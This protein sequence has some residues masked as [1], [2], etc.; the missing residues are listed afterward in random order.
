MKVTAKQQKNHR[1]RILRQARIS[2]NNG[3]HVV[4]VPPR[5]KGPVVKNWPVLRLRKDQLEEYFASDDNIGWMTGETSGD[6]VDVD[7]DCKAAIV[8]GKVFLPK[9][10]RIHG[11]EGRRT[12]HYWYGAT[13]IPRP[14]KFVDVDGKCLVEL[15]SDGQQTLI[16]PSIHPNGEQLRWEGTGEPTRIGG[17]DLCKAVRKIAAGALLARH[18]PKLGRRHDAANA[19]A[20]MLL[21]GGWKKN[22]T[23]GF[24]EAVAEAAGDDESRQRVKDVMSTATRIAS[25]AAATG[26]PSLAVIMG[27]DVVSRIRQILQIAA[28]S[29]STLVSGTEDWPDPAL[30]GDELLPVKKFRL[31]LLPSSFRPLVEDVSE[32]MQTPPDYAGAAAV[33]TLAGC[34]NRRARIQPKVEDVSWSIVPNLWGAIVG[35]PGFMKSPVL[36]AITAPLNRIEDFWRAEYQN[37][38]A[39]Y[40]GAK[41]QADLR[42]AAWRELYKKALKEGTEVPAQPDASLVPPVERQLITT[43]STFEKLHEILSRNPAGLLVVRDELTGW[44]AEL[45]RDGREGERSFF[46]QAWSGDQPYKL[47]RIGRGSIYVPAVCVSLIGNI[48]PARLRWYLA[49]AVRGGANDDGLFQRFQVMVWPDPPKGDW[50]LVD[51]PPNARALAIAER[52]F[53]Q[54]ANLPVDDPP[55][56]LRFGPEAQA[57]FEAWWR[58]LEKKVRSESGLAPVMVAHLAKYRS[59]MPSLSA[60]FEMADRLADGGHLRDVVYAS[61]DHAEEAIAFC[62][63]LE[64]HAQ[65]V[66][67]C[68][69]SPE[70]RA[71][72]ELGKHIKRS[73]IPQ[74]FTTRDVYIKGWSGLDKPETARAALSVLE[75]AGWVRRVVSGA[76]STGGRP[77]ENWIVN[78]KAPART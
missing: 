3:R 7:L 6:L 42:L 55:V 21:R 27:D 25:G 48:Q 29:R 18:W 50:K 60:L 1:E 40:E 11:R 39:D 30:L 12:S 9:T 75:D 22:E 41:A 59:L 46:L 65:R 19:L 61:R 37:E 47:E 76:P 10:E 69:V 32:R 67:A 23:A 2:L 45:D 49:D 44:L 52:V 28:G 36:H 31:D 56:Q 5:S 17:D 35:S 34:V 13:P 78:P 64:S 68:V 51:R 70:C 4:P 38:V 33:V 14:M 58:D 63:Y 26:T 43:D 73:D 72:R 62:G 66:Y 53:T 20:G 77:A 54:L 16:P 24:I 15:R 74:S 8:L 71:A 57:L